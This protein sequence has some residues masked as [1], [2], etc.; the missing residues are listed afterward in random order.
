MAP[1]PGLSAPPTMVCSWKFP[2]GPVTN[3]YYILLK[4]VRILP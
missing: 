3:V 2:P 4:V 1:G